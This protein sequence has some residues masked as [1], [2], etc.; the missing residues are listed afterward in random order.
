M[1]ARVLSACLSGVEAALIRVEVDV[2]HGLPAFATVG[3]PDPTI[4]E[5]RDRVR[6]AVRNSGY[7]FPAERVTVNLA[8]AD[9]R[10]EGVSFD[11]PIA[12]GLLVAAHGVKAERLDSLLVVGELALDGT[13]RPVRGVLPMA[14]AAERAGLRGCLLPPGN[15]REAAMASGLDVYPVPTL[16]EAAAFLN[17]ERAI[18]PV[19]AGGASLLSAGPEGD[20]D[21]AEVRG[22]AHAKRALEIAAAGRHHALL[23]GAPGTGK[24]LLARRLP[25]ILP[26]LSLAEALEVSTVW[27]VAGL[28]PASGLV[29]ARPFRAPHHTISDAGLIGGG[30]GPHPGEVTLAHLGVLFLDELSEFAPHVLDTL[31]QPLETGTVALARAEGRVTLP[32]AFQLVG[33][34][35]PCRRG[36]RSR[37]LCACTPAERG[38]YLTRLSGPLIDRIDVQVEVP[39]VPY[40]DLAPEGLA[41]ETSEVVRKRVLAARERQR[42]RFGRLGA[43]VNSRMTG[44]QMARWC[45]LGAD[46]RR[47]MA[48]AVDRLGLSARAHDRV[49]R[50]ARTIADLDASDDISR[51]HVAEALQYRGVEAWTD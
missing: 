47:L 30:R 41:G 43:G 40:R 37:D 44:R 18:E 22:Q 38:R 39:A 33:A 17:G 7:T 2:S 46:A 19:P 28:A 32:A 23:V 11:L 14:L 27:S 16:A 3:L 29:T 36:C 5:S 51:D 9:L 35:N 31:R 45:R 21:L 25:T 8:P 4:R 20:L 50:V 34:M 42:E 48:Q 12:L 24:T 1:L 15:A 49:L 26:P 13:A 10:K 6:T